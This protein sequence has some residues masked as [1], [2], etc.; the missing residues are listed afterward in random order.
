MTGSNPGVCVDRCLIAKPMRTMLFAGVM[1]LGLASQAGAQDRPAAFDLLNGDIPLTIDLTAN[2]EVCAVEGERVFSAVIAALEDEGLA[3]TRFYDTEPDHRLRVQI[4]I[5]D[6]GRSAVCSGYLFAAF[7]QAAEVALTFS[8]ADH[9]DFVTLAQYDGAL[10]LAG[11]A[12]TSLTERVTA[13]VYAR[14]R[15]AMELARALDQDSGQ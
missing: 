12:D 3:W 6:T 9:E 11:A 15:H 5:F 8:D 1:A 2:D 14:L 10:L 4:R 13:E 7:E